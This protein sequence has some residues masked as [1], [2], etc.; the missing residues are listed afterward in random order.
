[1]TDIKRY[2]L[3]MSNGGTV[4]ALWVPLM[5]SLTTPATGYYYTKAIECWAV[6][7]ELVI[8]RSAYGLWVS[9]D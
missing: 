7:S 4:V 9:P 1:M 6:F 3:I 2:I 8:S 5:C